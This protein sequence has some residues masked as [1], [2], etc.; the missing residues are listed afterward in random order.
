MLMIWHYRPPSQ[1]LGMDFS[2][3]IMSGIK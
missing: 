3:V 2:K 1:A